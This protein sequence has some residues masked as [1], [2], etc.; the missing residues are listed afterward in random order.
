MDEQQSGQ[1]MPDAKKC[2]Q[3]GAALPTG[4]LNGL[5]PACLLKQG[6]AAETAMRQHI[7]DVE[8]M[9]FNKL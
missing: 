1:T 2:P 9:V 5:C 7:R 4:A 8:H 3:C 6:A